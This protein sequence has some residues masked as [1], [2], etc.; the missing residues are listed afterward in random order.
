MIL[1]EYRVEFM[2]ERSFQQENAGNLYAME[3]EYTFEGKAMTRMNKRFITNYS[4]EFHML[5]VTFNI[6]RQ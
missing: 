1:E 6:N 4:P 2:T 5:S 3:N